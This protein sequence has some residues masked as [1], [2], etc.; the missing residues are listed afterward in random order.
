VPIAH[1]E[2][3]LRTG[4]MYNPFPEEMNRKLIG[5][6]ATYNFAA[7]QEARVNLLQVCK[8]NPGIQSFV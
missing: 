6:L 8:R 5:S 4:N 7:T 2:A 1:V 3:G